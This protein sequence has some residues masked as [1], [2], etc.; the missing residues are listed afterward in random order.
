MQLY[1]MKEIVRIILLIVVIVGVTFAA[2]KFIMRFKKV[3]KI[4]ELVES[5]KLVEIRTVKLDTNNLSIPIYGNLKSL[6]EIDIFPE[7]GG[8]LMNDDFREGNSY[9]KGDVIAVFD[10]SELASNIKSQKSNLLNQTAKLVTDMK[11]DFP[12]VVNEWETFLNKIDFE[13]RL[14]EL[15]KVSDI[16]L[17]KY[18]AGKSIYSTYFSI[19]AQENRL[20]KYTLTAPF[21]GTLIEALLKPGTV[22]RAGQKMGKFINSFQFELEANV[23]LANGSRVNIGDKV[24]L[25]SNDIDGEWEGT[26]KRINRTL[27]E[28]SQNMD[29]FILINSSSLYNGMYLFGVAYLGSANNSIVVKR[30]LLDGDQIFIIEDGILKSRKISILQI[31]EEVAIISG[32]ENGDIIL[33]EAINETFEGMKVRYN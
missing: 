12:A 14:P 11:F 10:N 19:Q 23:T 17:K 22:A 18:L 2:Y 31:N 16:K 28:A 21:D 1:G 8:R 33:S 20:A 9:Y 15:P 13:T 24:I 29:V 30:S 5:I 3:P 25:Q 4:N 27:S 32:L 26:I 6:N 7:V